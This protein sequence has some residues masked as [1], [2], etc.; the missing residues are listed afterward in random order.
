[1][2]LGGGQ[3]VGA[4]CYYLRI[5]ESNIILDAGIGRERGME[6]EPKFHSLLTS[7]FLQSMNQINQIYISHAHMDHVG[8]LLRLMK[9]SS[10]SGV[11]M[12]EM[13]RILAEFQLYD[14]LYVGGRTN[15]EDARLAAKSLIEKTATVSYM[16]KIDFGNYKATFLPAGHI[17][18]AMM[19]LFEAGKR[20]ILYTGDYSLE[21]TL[22]T[23]GCMIPDDMQIDTL[24]MC[25]LHAKHPDYT[26]KS[27][28]IFKTA[29]YAL[30]R[31]MDDKQSV[32][33]HVQQLSKGVEFLKCLNRRNKAHVP[34]Y[35]DNTVMNV[36]NKMEQLSVPVLEKYN[37]IMTGQIPKEPHIYLTS[38]SN[39]DGHGF[40]KDIKVDFSL[41]EDFA[42][43]KK[44][45][46][47]LNAKQAVIVHCGKEVVQSGR[48][49]EQEMMLDGESRTQ[50]IFAEE[51]EVYRL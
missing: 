18:G 34:I 26:K 31:V 48:T 14:R 43:M 2:P 1:M 6:F 36:I 33:C 39:F 49:I 27:N 32:R 24:I 9:Q 25:G 46:K 15:D 30:H 40:Y 3:R 45:I 44:F 41:H 28:G 35:L 20:K 7:F 4:S 17:P 37:K 10:F 21:D 51:K 8:Y 23:S 42:G 38:G 47:K 29:D 16:Q 22:L 13:T 19:I 12:T 50:F 11:Y 5:G